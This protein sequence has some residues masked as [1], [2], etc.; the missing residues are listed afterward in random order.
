MKVLQQDALWQLEDKQCGFVFT[1]NLSKKQLILQR[2]AQLAYRS[3]FE[4]RTLA[5]NHYHK[6][7]ELG[8]VVTRRRE[9]QGPRA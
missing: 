7:D 5:I 3:L 2:C 9:R 4:R 1:V 6:D 8:A